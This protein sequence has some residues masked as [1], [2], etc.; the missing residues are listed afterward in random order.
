MLFYPMLYSVD[1]RATIP[2]VLARSC[3][4]HNAHR[5]FIY[6]FDSSD[7]SSI[8]AL[9]KDMAASFPQI[10]WLCLRFDH[11]CDSDIVSFLLTIDDHN[12]TSADL[13]GTCIIFSH[14]RRLK[15]CSLSSPM[16]ARMYMGVEIV[17][18]IHGITGLCDRVVP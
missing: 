11:R 15:K 9:A 13:M 18:I 12:R 2:Q 8:Y 14:V 10:N 17:L 7:L 3:K 16:Y 1:R 6:L 4:Y 5:L